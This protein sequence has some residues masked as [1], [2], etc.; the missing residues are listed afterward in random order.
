MLWRRLIFAHGS[1]RDQH[2]GDDRE[3][4]GAAEAAAPIRFVL[5]WSFSAPPMTCVAPLAIV[6][7]LAAFSDFNPMRRRTEWMMANL[8]PNKARS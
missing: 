5:V 1:H 7:I 6:C 4:G 3:D 8:R 2:R